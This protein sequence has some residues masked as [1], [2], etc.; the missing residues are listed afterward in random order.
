M[1]KISAGIAY[2]Q[3]CLTGLASALNAQFGFGGKSA[4]KMRCTN[5]FFFSDKSCHQSQYAT[6]VINFFFFFFFFF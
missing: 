3:N 6:F 2:K 5:I 1:I 4:L